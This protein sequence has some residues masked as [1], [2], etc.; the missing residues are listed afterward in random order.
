MDLHVSL[1]EL[2]NGNFVEVQRNKA[3]YKAAPGKQINKE[4]RESKWHKLRWV[5]NYSVHTSVCP[6][7][8][9]EKVPKSRHSVQYFIK[10]YLAKVGRTMV[11]Q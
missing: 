1:E 3:V 2:Y 7:P 4:K 5:M 8:T 6:S 9:L 11:S 10:K